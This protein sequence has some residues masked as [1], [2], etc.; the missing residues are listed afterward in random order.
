M[1]N[2]LYIKFTEPKR[3]FF[4]FFFLLDT[5]NLFLIAI[6]LCKFFFRL[7]KSLFPCRVWARLSILRNI[8]IRLNRI[9]RQILRQW[10]FRDPWAPIWPLLGNLASPWRTKSLKNCLFYDSLLSRNYGE[11][12]RSVIIVYLLRFCVPWRDRVLQGSRVHFR[13]EKLESRRQK[14]AT[15]SSA[16]PLSLSLLF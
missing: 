15:N 12:D 13:A 2:A 3:R 10:T 9:C 6:Y 4:S 1:V 11:N 16:C 5:F 8:S 7:Q 14:I